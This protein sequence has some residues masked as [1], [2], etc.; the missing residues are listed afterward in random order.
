MAS[1]QS[2]VEEARQ[3]ALSVDRQLPK[4]CQRLTSVRSRRCLPPVEGFSYNFLNFGVCQ[5][6]FSRVCKG[7]I[8]ASHQ[9]VVLNPKLL[10]PKSTWKGFETGQEIF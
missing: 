9:D 8:Y 2:L 6:S 10:L 1:V 5:I 7:L 3:I 4:K